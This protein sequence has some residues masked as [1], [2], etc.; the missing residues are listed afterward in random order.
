MEEN[1]YSYWL[2][3]ALADEAPLSITSLNN[4]IE[5]GIAIVGGGYTGLWTAIMLKQQSPESDITIIDKGLCGSGASGANGGC[6]LT[7]STK[8][9]TMKKLFGEQEA[10]RLVAESES[11]IYR[12]DAFCQE[13]N[14]DAEL[15]RHGTY[16]TATN[17][18][19]AGTMTPVVD[20]LKKLGVNSWQQED[21]GTI[22]NKAGSNKHIEGY[23]SPAAASVQPALLVRGLLKVAIS[24]GIKVYEN[25]EMLA[26]SYGTPAVI[27]TTQGNIRAEKVVLAMNAWMAE[28]FK[29]FKNS[30]V[31]VSSDMVITD[32]IPELLKEKGPEQGVTVVDS[33]IFVHYYRDTRDGRLMLGKG[34][35]QFSFGNKVDVMFNRPSHYVDLLTSSFKTLFP[36]F[37]STSFAANWTGGSDRST[38]GLP[39]FGH[40]E[41]QDNIVY[42]LGYSGNGVAQTYIGGQILSSL[43][44]EQDN[45]WTRCGLVG[46]PRGYFPPEP[47]RWCGAMTVRNAVR[48][49]EAAEDEGRAP[50]LIDKLLSKLAG[51]A[52]KADKI[53]S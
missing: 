3:Q 50:W 30:I 52:G 4:D 8:Y 33:R 51:P 14:I 31:V 19:Q 29:S 1:N 15:Y 38:T 35:N 48:R 7:W 28:K 43:V 5:T 42:G 45:E 34:G 32:P 40:L 17:E 23:Y 20:E 24:L 26:V 47:F 16:Y 10:K 37:P 25:T 18:A 6:M 46:G 36:S 9:P 11:A 44:L 49:K 39:F 27:K 13:H 41:G 12:I 2:K 22:G 21:K 53:E